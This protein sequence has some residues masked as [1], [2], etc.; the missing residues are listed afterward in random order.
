M[1]VEAGRGAKTP[2]AAADEYLGALSW[3][4]L[5]VLSGRA[6]K[7]EEL[8]RATRGLGWPSACFLETMIHGGSENQ[9]AATQEI[10]S[11]ALPIIAVAVHGPADALDTRKLSLWK[12]PAGAAA[13]GAE[14]TT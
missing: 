14:E 6:A 10:R 12:V 11:D 5:I 1:T 2:D 7:V 4:P 9:L 13:P 3:W 8:W